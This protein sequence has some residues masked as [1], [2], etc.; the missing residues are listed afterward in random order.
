[1]QEKFVEYT[2]CKTSEGEQCDKFFENATNTG[3]TCVCTV[4]FSLSP[5]F[6]GDVFMYYGLSN[7]YQVC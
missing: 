1:M 5:A 4:K 6:K 3:K 7:F 2:H